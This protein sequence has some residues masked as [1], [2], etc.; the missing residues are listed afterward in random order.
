[1][2][3][4]LACERVPKSIQMDRSVIICVLTV[5]LYT[6]MRLV[7]A[8]HMPVTIQST[9]GLTQASPPSSYHLFCYNSPLSQPSSGDL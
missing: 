8:F 2:G 5:I 1:M 9:Q 6:G 4:C 3:L 7:V